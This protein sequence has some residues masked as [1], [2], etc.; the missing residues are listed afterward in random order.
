MSRFEKIT[1]GRYSGWTLAIPE[2]FEEL[3]KERA[4]RR[5]FYRDDVKGF[6]GEFVLKPKER[7]PDSA[8]LV[9]N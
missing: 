3:A 2:Q 8:N 7:K 1:A 9:V 5:H 4:F 6:G